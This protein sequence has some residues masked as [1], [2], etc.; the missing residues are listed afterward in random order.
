MIIKFTIPGEPVAKAR[1]G[2]NAWGGRYLPPKTDAFQNLVKLAFAAANPGWIPV[3]PYPIEISIDAYYQ[4]PESWPKKKKAQAAD[5][6]VY[7]ISRPDLDNV[8][9]SVLDGLNKV[10]WDDDRQ[11]ISISAWKGFSEIPRTEVEINVIG[12]KEAEK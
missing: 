9:K 2:S 3:K 5:N 11:V 12:R 8:I 1:P 10:C 7:K 6:M 4:I